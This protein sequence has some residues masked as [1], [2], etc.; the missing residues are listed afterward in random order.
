MRKILSFILTIW[1]VLL[2]A[3][4]VASVFS[5]KILHYNITNGTAVSL[6]L[7]ALVLGATGILLSYDSP[8]EDEG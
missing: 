6:A 8:A 7:L 3:I 1:G 2:I 5:G 4:V